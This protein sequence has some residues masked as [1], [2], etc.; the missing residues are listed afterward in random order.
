MIGVVV[1]EKPEWVLWDS[2]HQILYTAHSDKKKSGGLQVTASYTGE[3]LQEKLSGGKCFVAID[4]TRVIGT[5]SVVIKKTNRWFCKGLSAY[6]M[7]DAVLPEYQGRGVY[8][9]LDAARDEYVNQKGISVIYMHTSERN[10]KMQA[11]K[12]KQGY[13]LVALSVS[14]KTDYYSVIM[15]RWLNECPFSK[16]YCRLRYTLSRLYIKTKYKKGAV[17]R[18]L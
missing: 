3:E 11:I 18:F 2:I 9:L 15:V 12:E 14:S 8:T 17:K 13:R 5:A 4:D 7:L 10:K 16:F 6:Y 1:I